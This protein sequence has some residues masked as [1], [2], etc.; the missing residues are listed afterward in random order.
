MWEFHTGKKFE[1]PKEKVR[2]RERECESAK[3]NKLI[4]GDFLCACTRTI[5]IVSLPHTISQVD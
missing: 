5:V 3:I 1:R 2:V 4:V